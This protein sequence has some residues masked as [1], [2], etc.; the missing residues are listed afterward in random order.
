MHLWT[1]FY[2]DV[3][4][5][6]VFMFYIL[7]MLNDFALLQNFASQMA[8]G[9]D[10]KAGGAQMGVMQGPMVRFHTRQSHCSIQ[11]P[12]DVMYRTQSVL[13][14]PGNSHCVHLY[15]SPSG[16]WPHFG[17][18]RWRFFCG[19]RRSYLNNPCFLRLLLR[20]LVSNV[21]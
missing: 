11:T 1:V 16:A 19:F 2:E 8:G 17:S 12:S 15:K 10:D 13:I 14:A 18:C 7:T 21:S 3:D 5:W 4:L 20:S 6:I 9:F